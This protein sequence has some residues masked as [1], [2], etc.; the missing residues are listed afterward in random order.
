MKVALFC[1]AFDPIHWGH[2]GAASEV[3]FQLG[4]DRVL[5]SPTGQPPHKRPLAS[6]SLRLAMLE[7]ALAELDDPRLVASRLEQDLPGPHYTASSLERLHQDLSANDPAL[8]LY[9]ILGS[10]A[11]ATLAGWQRPATIRRLAT[12]VVAE[13]LGMVKTG[14]AT[15]EPVLSVPTLEPVLSGATLEPVLSTAI[16]E[17]AYS[18]EQQWPPQKP[19]PPT[20]QAVLR[21]SW[22]GVAASS[23]DIRA[24]LARGA[25]VGYLLPS[26]VARLIGQSQP[27]PTLKSLSR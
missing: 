8:E 19:A 27:Y 20:E 21:V 22:P 5:L 13:R 25:P 18:L 16:V 17:K 15:L 3:G 7:A 9:L 12:L 2:L 14:A 24:R 4:L 10:D 11:A 6:P 1:G 23:S 26:S